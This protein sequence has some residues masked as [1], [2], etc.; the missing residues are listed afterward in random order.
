MKVI[1]PINITD[2]ILT[3]ST[4]YETAPTAY[5]G[6]TTYA[7]NDVA[8]VAGAA[9]LITVYKSL[10]G[11]NTGNAPA[12][13]PT[14]W[15]S[16]GTTYQVYS[17]A[18]TYALGDYVIDTTNHLI[19]QSLIA[20]NLGNALTD[21]TK[22]FESGKTNRWAMFDTLRSTGTT[23]PNTM[24]IVLTPGSRTDAIALLGLTAKTVSISI[25]N[26]SVYYTYNADLI[27]REVTSWYDY[28][29]AEFSTKPSIVLFDVPPYSGVITITLTNTVS[30]V[31][32]GA[33]IIGRQHYI[34]DIQ[35]NS[36]VQTLN[37]STIDRNFAGGI[38]TLIQRRNVPKTTQ[39]TIFETHHLNKIRNLRDDLNAVPAVWSGLTD[40]AQDYFESFLI[41]GI[42]KDFT[43]TAD[44][45]QTAM[46][47]ITLE[48]I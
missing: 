35:Y 11:S 18:I 40:N 7:L 16:V 43:I 23:V 10:Q 28:F 34:G 32:C 42:Y 21:T 26:G 13:S 47:N 39:N 17:G 27:T 46:L 22:W 4:V 3:S 20:G 37:F 1:P 19:Y 44:N 25:S 41:L 6:G 14:W 9:G 29:F 2:A 12:S 48:E 45:P 15:V 5:A 31:T 36:Q 8:S 33:C 24:T 30:N 38:N